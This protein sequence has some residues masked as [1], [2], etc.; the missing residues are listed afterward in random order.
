MKSSQNK[1]SNLLKQSIA[2][3]IPCYRECNHILGVLANIG[4]EVKSIYIID[5]ACP[6]QTGSF[7]STKSTDPRIKVIRHAINKGVGGATFTGY[8]IALKDGHDIIVKIDGDAQMDPKLIP[9]IAAPVINGRA[10]Y[11]KGNRFHSGDA[12]SSMPLLRII[13]NICLSI[14]SKF[15]SGYWNIFDP[16]NGF[17]AIHTSTLIQLKEKKIAY[18]YFFESDMLFWLGILRAVVEDVPMSASY[19][20]E[21]SGI[22]ILKVIPEFFMKHFLNFLRRVYYIYFLSFPGIATIQLV[23]GNFLLLFG[24][25]FGG[26]NWYKSYY[27]METPATAGTVVLAALPVILGIQLVLSFLNFD[28]KNTPKTP[29]QSK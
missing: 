28:S 9:I 12:V 19:G 13:G 14:L 16:T 24:I 29:I 25:S 26:Y 27:I 10:D 4:K 18:G 23:L 8:K 15:S 5:D 11:A 7:V 22:V 1:H 3:I 20:N 21:K 2:V 17:T 6:D